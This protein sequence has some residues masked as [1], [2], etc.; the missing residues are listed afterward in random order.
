MLVL[1]V[2]LCSAAAVSGV[3]LTTLAWLA[4]RIPELDP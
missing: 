1:L 3:V 4:P 2:V